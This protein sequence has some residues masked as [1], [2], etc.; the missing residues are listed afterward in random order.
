MLF[1]STPAPLTA[2]TSLS[3]GLDP[4]GA[5]ANAVP[6]VSLPEGSFRP[7]REDSV[8]DI[9][10]A[11]RSKRTSASVK[12]AAEAEIARRANAPV[13]PLESKDQSRTTSHD[14]VMSLMLQP[15]APQSAIS[16]RAPETIL[17]LS[18]SSSSISTNSKR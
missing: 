15:S 6:E 4:Q 14:Q 13:Q 2:S 16:S 8:D 12:A 11:L 10:S 5:L 18:P 1:R 17:H 9:D 7:F 3:R